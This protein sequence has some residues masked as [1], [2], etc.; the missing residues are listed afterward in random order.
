MPPD[1]VERATGERLRQTGEPFDDANGLYDAC[2]ENQIEA[3]SP[4]VEGVAAPVASGGIES[5]PPGNTRESTTNMTELEQK[6]KGNQKVTKR[7][8][9]RERN[10]AT[11][12]F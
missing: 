4:C 6:T 11:F 7:L 5:N 3:R 12:D 9:P 8:I 2:I 1:I 10:F